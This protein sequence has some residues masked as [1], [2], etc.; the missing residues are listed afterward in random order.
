MLRNLPTHLFLSALVLCA[1]CACASPRGSVGGS[2]NVGSYMRRCPQTL[3]TVSL[4]E[5]KNAD[6]WR[7]YSQRLPNLGSVIP[8]V[9]LLVQ[10]TNCLAIV[11]RGSAMKAMQRERELAA[12]GEVR[13]GTDFG[14]GQLV[15]AD[16]TIIP[17][18]Q[19]S[20]EYTN[21]G[22]SLAAGALLGRGGA[23]FAGSFKKNSAQTTL[24]LVDNRSGVQIAASIGSAKGTS[25]R[26]TG[27]GGGYAQ[28]KEGKV[29][30]QAFADS[31]NKLVLALMNYR[32]QRV[33]GGLG[34]GGQLEVAE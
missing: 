20:G 2:S 6:W 8:I 10:Q 1:L 15:A 9:R 34:Q 11:E 24:L 18:V 14:P 27:D 19:L 33:H 4:L 30:A 7:A 3:G 26:L 31:I 13:P 5:D 32:A 22:A 25:F 28:S 12:S 17:S 21:Q 16:Y 23:L 29:L